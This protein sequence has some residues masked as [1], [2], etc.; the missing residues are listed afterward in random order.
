MALAFTPSTE[1]P[2][3]RGP[4]AL[5]PELITAVE[6]SAKK[7]QSMEVTIARDDIRT[8]RRQLSSQKIRDK[9]DVTTGTRP[10]ANGNVRFIF[11]A[12]LKK[13]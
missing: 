12:T 8:L 4:I 5:A 2:S 6:E 7:G 10:G 11:K 3:G 1:N 9:Y 13:N